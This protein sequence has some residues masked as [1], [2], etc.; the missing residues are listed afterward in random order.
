[1]SAVYRA[2]QWTRHKRNYDL[3]IAAA[4][5]SYLAAF[6]ALG[7]LAWRGERAVSD[8]ILL[9]RALG[10]CAFVMLHVILCIGPLARLDR[11]FL[12]LLYNR[13]HLGVTMFCLAL[14]H[15][16]LALGFYHGFGVVSP[17]ASLLLSNTRFSSLSQ[18]PF[19]M[20]GLGAL[21]I[22]FLMASTSH[23]F[24]LK[25]LSPGTWKV[26]HMFVY[27][28]WAMLVLHVALGPLQAER[29]RVYL[30]LIG[31]GAAIVCSLHLIAA[32]R[33]RCRDGVV[34]SRRVGW[35]EVARVEDI[36]M[37]RAKVVRI[38]G[39][40]RVA[41]FRHARGLSAL[42]NVCAHQGGPLGEGKI[43]DACVTCPWHGYQYRPADGQSPPP[44]TEKVKT[45]RVRVDGPTVLLDPNPLPPGTA[46][47]PAWVDGLSSP[48]ERF[49]P[50]YVGYLSLSPELRRFFLKVVPVLVVAMIA[51]GACIAAFQRDPGKGVW[52]Q[53]Q[54]TF[55]GI[56]HVSPYPLLLRA[57]GAAMLLVEEGKHGD[58]PRRAAWDG[59]GVRVS[60]SVIHRDACALL[61]IASNPD[62]IKADPRQVA[63][64][65]DTFSAKRVSVRG[66]IIDPKCYAGA[67]KPGDAKPH[68]ACAAL[69]IRG[70]IPPMLAVAGSRGGTE[71]YLLCDADGGALKG[72]AL[73]TIAKRA[74]EMVETEGELSRLGDMNLLKVDAGSL[75]RLSG[76]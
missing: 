8:P 74:G 20:F 1:M 19:E 60:G 76:E 42:T 30:V 11:R 3:V 70:G 37:N 33:E 57:D 56:I 53:E 35:L 46:V 23:D 10:T 48:A 31:G 49:E 4:V 55:E 64:M 73:E 51:C 16:V 44:F 27:V 9:I 66:E 68:K 5:A 43:I 18:F 39:G 61:E 41:I 25:N 29:S 34:P 47:A 59:R 7:K 45:F 72:A 58:T 2:V 13:R 32:W 50:F 69:C 75:T 71:Y 40:D 22:L 62:A 67:M 21:L 15:A 14:L 26:L 24:W 28:A 54:A 52:N 6:F 36:P 17:P 65:R 63:L 38:P 12:P